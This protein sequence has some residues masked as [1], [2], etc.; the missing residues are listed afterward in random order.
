M[1]PLGF[2]TSSG[3]WIRF[4]ALCVTPEQCVAAAVPGVCSYGAE[5]Q[6]PDGW[7]VS[8]GFLVA[9]KAELWLGDPVHSMGC[10]FP[11]GQPSH[12]TLLA[13][14]WVLWVSELQSRKGD[15]W[16]SHPCMGQH[17]SRREPQVDGSGFTL[18][19]RAG[20]ASQCV[21]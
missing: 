15:P 13:S 6:D 1:T 20:V 10:L 21:S 3:V 11:D 4:C 5:V 7:A 19:R 17:S 14:L 18:V 16:L 12:S 9:W 8:D 2:P